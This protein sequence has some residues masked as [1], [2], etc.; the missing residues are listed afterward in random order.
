MAGRTLGGLSKSHPGHAVSP[1]HDTRSIWR[2]LLALAAPV[3]PVFVAVFRFL[4]PYDE[5]GSPREIFNDLLANPGFENAATWTETFVAMT[6][7]AGVV[8]V[9]WV[10]RRGAPVLT[11]VGTVLAF[12]GFTALF[13]GGSTDVITYVTATEGG[14]DRETAFQLAWGLES[15]AQAAVTG[16]IFVLG[17]L[18]GCVILGLA[19]WRARVVP[20]WLALG[21]AVS[22]PIHLVAVMTGNRPLDLVGWGLTAVGF[23]AASWVLL[24]MRDDDFDLRPVPR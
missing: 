12:A 11:A 23:G 1:V 14:L 6:A 17:H 9:A 18:I 24:R 10:S 2:V 13:V 15:S 21:L 16:I 3:T 19:M 20:A 4:L 8:A 7:V 5:A 22:Q